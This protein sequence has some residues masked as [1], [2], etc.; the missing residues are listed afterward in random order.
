M[1]YRPNSTQ[2][3]RGSRYVPSSSTNRNKASITLKGYLQTARSVAYVGISEVWQRQVV[4]DLIGDVGR[5]PGGVK[6]T[7]LGVADTRCERGELGHMVADELSNEDSVGL[8]LGKWLA[9][10][11]SRWKLPKHVY[12][13]CRPSF[14]P[15]QARR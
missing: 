15:Q 9:G 3:L 10:L 5:E 13:A 6:S 1:N 11:G 2:G 4:V 7:E 8:R 12:T 14:I